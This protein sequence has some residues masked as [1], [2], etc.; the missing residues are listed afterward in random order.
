MADDLSPKIG[1]L[2]ISKILESTNSTMNTLAGT[3][4]YQ[5]PEMFNANPS[6]TLKTD[7]WALGITLYMMFLGTKPYP[8]NNPGQLIFLIMEGKYNP[9]PNGSDPDLKKLTEKILCVNPLSRPSV[10]NI[11][12]DPNLVKNLKIY[13]LLD[14]V[15][16]TKNK[17]SKYLNE[18]IKEKYQNFPKYYLKNGLRCVDWMT[19]VKDLRCPFCCG[20]PDMA[21]HFI[22]DIKNMGEGD[23]DKVNWN[24]C[25]QL[26][27]FYHSYDCDKCNKRFMVHNDYISSHY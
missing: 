2:G 10:E 13:G 3:L 16:K 17:V 4:M 15:T 7:I 20:I 12:D 22:H 6:Y 8:E 23:P 1:D 9:I 25:D 14:L 24:H 27:Y 11:L 18:Q 5:A 26:D 19:W 21:N